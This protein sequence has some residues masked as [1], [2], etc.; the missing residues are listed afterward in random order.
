MPVGLLKPIV[1]VVPTRHDLGV[2]VVDKLCERQL[3]REVLVICNLLRVF[4][5]VLDLVD[6]PDRRPLPDPG[7]PALKLTFPRRPEEEEAVLRMRANLSMLQ[8][9]TGLSR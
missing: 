2:P 8:L 6:P 4:L 1:R 7:L 5:L 9:L 3:E